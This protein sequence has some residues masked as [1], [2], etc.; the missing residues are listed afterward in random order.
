MYLVVVAVLLVQKLLDLVEGV[1]V[2]CLLEKKSR[3]IFF[4]FVTDGRAR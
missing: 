1:S 3:N 2:K 4:F